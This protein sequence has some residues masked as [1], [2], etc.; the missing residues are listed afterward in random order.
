VCD[1]KIELVSAKK[2]ADMDG[3]TAAVHVATGG[4]VAVRDRN[5][6]DLY[7]LTYQ[8]LVSG[9]LKNVPGARAFDVQVALK[10]LGLKGNRKYSAYNFVSKAAEAKGATKNTPVVYNHDSVAFVSAFMREKT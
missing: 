7:Q 9:V 5:L 3:L 10:T 2:I 4:A 8:Q 6:T 1:M